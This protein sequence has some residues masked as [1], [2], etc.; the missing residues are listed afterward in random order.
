MAL[1]ATNPITNRPYSPSYNPGTESGAITLEWRSK[2]IL[3]ATIRPFRAPIV[4][5]YTIEVNAKSGHVRCSCPAYQYAHEGRPYAKLT[6]A[7]SGWCKHIQAWWEQLAAEIVE[8]NA[9]KAEDEISTK[10]SI[11]H[12]SADEAFSQDHPLIAQARAAT[13]RQELHDLRRA[14]TIIAEKADKRNS[15]ALRAL[16]N[17][18]DYHV[19]F[20]H[21]QSNEPLVPLVQAFL[22]EVGR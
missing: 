20:P 17:E 10:G 9:A 4:R 21:S 8:H 13:L 5:R 22:A 15:P 18:I 19:R 16:C 7:C 3:T 11:H 6:D 12:M 14:A 2:N 1:A